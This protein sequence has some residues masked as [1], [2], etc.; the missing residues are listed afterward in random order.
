[1]KEHTV[2]KKSQRYYDL[3]DEQ[4]AYYVALVIDPQFKTLLLDED[5]GKVEAPKVIAHIKEILHEQYPLPTDLSTML[6]VAQPRV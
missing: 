3:I 4:D 1:M 2:L 5:L 6:S